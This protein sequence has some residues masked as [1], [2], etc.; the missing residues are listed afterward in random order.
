MLALTDFQQARDRLLPYLRRTPAQ[1]SETLSRKFGFPVHLKL[2][3]FQ[4]TGSFKPRA[5]F[6]RMLRFDESEKRRGVVAVS[7][8]NF[9]QGVAYAGNVL[10]VE[11]A[12]CMPENSPKNSVAAARGYG[13]SVELFPD[14]RLAFAAAETQRQ[15]GRVFIH[16]F[17]EPDV[18]AGNGSLGLELLDDV[19]EATALIVSV[20]GGGLMSG[21]VLAAKAVKPS[22][23]VF[24]VETQGA[25]ALDQAMRAGKVVEMTPTSL[26]KTLG[27]PYVSE[28]ALNVAQTHV[29]KHV[30]VSDR[31]AFEAQRFL[32]ERTKVLAELSAACT[33]AAAEKIRPSLSPS[34]RLVLILCGGN[35]SL[36]DLAG[37][38][39][40][41]P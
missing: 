8:G 35:V 31:E 32:L 14:I 26:A 22:L 15:A 7:G 20:G 18:V 38:R 3:L 13:A 21:V 4:K 29:E 19:P 1:A 6:N 34:D 17:D 27:A 30:L 9:A 40:R 41:F 28:T 37:Y 25:D 16:P 12:L 39:E 23:R 5:A 24:T 11:V 2:E 10:G 36:E 33:L